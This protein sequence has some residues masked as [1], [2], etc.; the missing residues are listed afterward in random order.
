MKKNKHVA[1]IYPISERL[2][3]LLNKTTC[4]KYELDFLN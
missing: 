1:V 4:L 3:V 2:A